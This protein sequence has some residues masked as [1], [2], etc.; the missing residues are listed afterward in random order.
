MTPAE[1][2]AIAACLSPQRI[3]TYTNACSPRAGED[4]TVAAL[5]LY[6]WNVEVSAALMVPIHL[7]EVAIRNAASDALTAVYGPR[8]PWSR[9]LAQALPAASARRYSAT[10]DLAAT[11]RAH[12]TTGKVI[13][14]LKF[15][16][17]EKL[18][19]SRHD[20]RLWRQHLHTVLPNLDTTKT[21]ATLRN[22]I[23]ADLGQ[24]RELRNRIAHHEPIFR[25][26]LADDLDA[27]RRLV[28][29]RSTEMRTWLDEVEEVTELIAAQP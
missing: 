25:R 16:F 9:S 12:P 22:D 1:A 13:P 4:Q 15:V 5:R 11:A 2:A 29:Y 10:R 6:R 14:E 17:W 21:I 3:A 18:F 7:C 23:R 19:T 27:L 8:W 26:Q 28:G 20:Q 24:I